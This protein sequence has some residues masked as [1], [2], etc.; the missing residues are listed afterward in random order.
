MYLKRVKRLVK[1]IRED[2]FMKGIRTISNFIGL[3]KIWHSLI[4]AYLKLKSDNNLILKDIQG[5]KM[6]L[7][8]SI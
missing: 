6:Y 7:D 1:I 2:G 4:I 8:L 3:T 5:R